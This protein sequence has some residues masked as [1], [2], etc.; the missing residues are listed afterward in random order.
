[1]NRKPFLILLT[2]CI[3]SSF[4][5]ACPNQNSAKLCANLDGY[6]LANCVANEHEKAGKQLKKTFATVLNQRKI[7]KGSKSYQHWQKSQQMWQA[8]VD[9]ECTSSNER[10]ST[11]SYAPVAFSICAIKK[12]K[13]REQELKENA[14]SLF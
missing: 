3:A 1:M 2:S 13:L 11:S 10:F 6:L 4:A 5:F 9:F 7:Y 12:I 14:N 8:W